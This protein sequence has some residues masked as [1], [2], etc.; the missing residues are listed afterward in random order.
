MD[1]QKI[2]IRSTGSLESDNRS[3]SGY[4]IRFNERSNKLYDMWS[5]K[6]FY[7]TISPEACTQEFLDQQDIRVLYNHLESG[8]S[9]A[10]SNKGTGTLTL[11]ADEN[12]VHFQF[13]CPET[14]SGQEILDGIRRG[15]ID[16]VSF[17]FYAD[18]N[19]ITETKNEDGTFERTVNKILAITEISLLDVTPAYSDTSVDN[20]SNENNTID[21]MEDNKVLEELQAKIEELEN[22]LNELEPKEVEEADREDKEPEKEKT[23]E[24]AEEPTEEPTETEENEDENKQER[25]MNKKFSLI[26]AI[27]S[28][29]NNGKL[30][31]VSQ[32]VSN[33]GAAELRS[34]GLPTAGQIQLPVE[35][36]D[37]P[38]PVTVNAFG[39]DVVVTDFLDIMEPLR[40]KNVLADAGARIL[41]GLVGDLQVPIMTAQNVGWAGEIAA[42][43]ESGAAF[44]HVLLQ[45]KRLTAYIDVSKQFLVQDSLGAEQM[46]RQDLINAI[47]TKLESTILGSAAGDANKPAG[48]FN[49]VTP[50]TVAAFSDI[51]DLEADLEDANYNG[52]FTYILSPKAKSAL[53]SMIKGTNGTGMV[54]ENGEVDGT[55]ALCT[56]NIDTETFAV[57]DWSKLA[58]GQWG[59]ID[60]T[61]DPY[62]Q[63]VNG[64]VRITINAFFDAK[65]LDENAVAYGTVSSN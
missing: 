27:R 43:A 24:P 16:K 61:I 3:I 14:P 46:L 51:A 19:D 6:F 34:A 15:D 37:D 18:P 63:A 35:H 17:A 30:D 5:D 12:G 8:H 13:N 60:L 55:P 45:P 44:D 4:C 47:Q 22:K 59:A 23:E 9:L 49:G 54:M 65:L 32:A 7:E 26:K 40:A 25:K 10:R 53:R 2:N 62:S 1:K 58:V 38:N 56:T 20:R 33:I 41:T 31:E 42:A 29:V 28:I 48:I 64:V 52:N 11:T 36:R 39:D 21:N 57:G 50:T